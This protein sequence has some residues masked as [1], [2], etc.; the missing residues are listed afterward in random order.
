MDISSSS[1]AYE[2]L[3]G[4]FLPAPKFHQGRKHAL[5]VLQII[6]IIIE[7]GSFLFYLFSGRLIDSPVTFTKVVAVIVVIACVIGF[8]TA[9]LWAILKE[10]LMPTAIFFVLQFLWVLLYCF[11][12]VVSI[13]AL[14]GIIEHDDQHPHTEL[15]ESW[16]SIWKVAVFDTVELVLYGLFIHDLWVMRKVARQQE[17]QQQQQLQRLEEAIDE[18]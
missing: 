6:P 8:H 14:T 9:N 2:L 17:T 15:S 3:A 12:G 10:R 13:L 4:S 16:L 18:E 5:I 11:V 7:I 1:E